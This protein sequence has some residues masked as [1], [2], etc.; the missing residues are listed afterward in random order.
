MD[1][2]V[3]LSREFL[4]PRQ[5]P[6]F[7]S[8]NQHKKFL[9]KHVGVLGEDEAYAEYIRER[10]PWFD[11]VIRLVRDQFVVHASPQHMRFFGVPHP[12]GHEYGMIVLLPREPGSAKPLES[13]NTLMLTIPRLARDIEEFLKWFNAYAVAAVRRNRAVDPSR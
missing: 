12:S 4:R 2:V 10:T 7:T 3:S 5:V 9:V 6:S 1:R 8:F 13:V 11:A